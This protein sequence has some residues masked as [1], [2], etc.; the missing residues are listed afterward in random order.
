M[1]KL[2]F[3]ILMLLGTFAASRA[4]SPLISQADSAYNAD[5]FRLAADIY[6]NVI[7]EEGPSA[8][9]Y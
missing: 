7:Q 2:L 4:E 9:L 3:A 8:K 6:L 1:K 5:N